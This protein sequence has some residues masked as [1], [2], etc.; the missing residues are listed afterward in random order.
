MEVRSDGAETSQGLS[1]KTCFASVCA[2]LHRVVELGRDV[3]DQAGVVEGSSAGP[4]R[5]R[6]E[7]ACR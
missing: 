4:N 2:G 1:E 3:I 6:V 5:V 7:G